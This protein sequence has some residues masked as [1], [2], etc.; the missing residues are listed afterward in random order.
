MTPGDACLGLASP[1]IGQS[2]LRHG[3]TQAGFSVSWRYGSAT[4]TAKCDSFSSGTSPTALGLP[5]TADP[6]SAKYVL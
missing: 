1:S 2:F 6:V 3:G 4:P 5:V